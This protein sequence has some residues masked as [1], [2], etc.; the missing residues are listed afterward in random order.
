[1][2]QN[3]KSGQVPEDLQQLYEEGSKN[4][5]P[6]R[7]FKSQFI[8][9]VFQQNTSGES[10]FAPGNTQSEVFK[11]NSEICANKSQVTGLPHS[12]M[13][14]KNPVK[15][16]SFEWAERRGDVYQKDGYYH[17]RTIATA[18]EKKQG[19]SMVLHGGQAN[20]TKD[21]LFADE[22]IHVEQAL[23]PVWHWS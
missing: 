8:N 17:V 15:P 14:W 4:S 1:M 6:P 19:S 13:S 18:I 9:K 12:I 3:I 21:E 16:A 23:E 5:P 11:K 20:L 2:C 22:S 7:L 10:V